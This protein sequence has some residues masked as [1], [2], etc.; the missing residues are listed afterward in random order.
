VGL[1]GS[2]EA[3]A[4]FVIVLETAAFELVAIVCVFAA[5]VAISV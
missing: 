5:I 1:L 2:V 4:A 3:V